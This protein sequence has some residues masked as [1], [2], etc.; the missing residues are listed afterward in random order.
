MQN[1]LKFFMF[2]LCFFSL[3]LFAYEEIRDKSTGLSFPLQVSFQVNGKDYLLK[4]TGVST[5]KKFFVKVY[6]IASYLQTGLPASSGDNLLQQIM[7]DNTAKQLT[8]KWVH[9]ASSD[10]IQEG[11]HDSFN[12]VLNGSQL[13]NEVNTFVGFFKQGAKVGDE[14][15]LRWAP[16]G[17]VEVFVNGNK[18]GS[19]TNSDFAKAL[20]SI[21]FGPN[22]VVDRDSLVSGSAF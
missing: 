22:S 13:Q 12:K 17:Y 1:S 19:L 10:K 18:V 2:F 4:A 9:D 15:I 8:L 7:Q 3:S 6:T 16:G 14:H 21:W 20:W 11:Y 5:R